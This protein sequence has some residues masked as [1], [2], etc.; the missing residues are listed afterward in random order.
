MRICKHNRVVLGR[1]FVNISVTKSAHFAFATNLTAEPRSTWTNPT[2][3]HFFV[4]HNN[5]RHATADIEAEDVTAA[6]SIAT[7]PKSV[8]ALRSQAFVTTSMRIV[9]WAKG[10]RCA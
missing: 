2:G 10:L 6:N 1:P 3:A 5:S 7:S 8:P 9:R 4:C